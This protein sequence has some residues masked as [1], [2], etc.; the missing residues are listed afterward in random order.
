MIAQSRDDRRYEQ[1]RE[2]RIR[3]EYEQKQR[4]ADDRDRR[5]RKASLHYMNE[6]KRTCTTIARR[7]LTR[8]H[9]T[10]TRT[11]THSVFQVF[12]LTKWRIPTRCSTRVKERLWYFNL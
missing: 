10:P 12:W 2:D 5:D 4:E 3:A 9:K 7:V 6:T 11:K 8:P 1:E